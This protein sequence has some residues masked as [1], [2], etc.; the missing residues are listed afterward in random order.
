MFGFDIDSNSPRLLSL[1]EDR[2]LIE[3]DLS[4]STPETGLLLRGTPTRIEQSAVPTCFTWYP[5]CTKE[6]FIITANS[7]FKF[8]LCNVTTKMCRK[9]LLGPLFGSPVKNLV[10]V[11]RGDRA[12]HLLA[13]STDNKVGIALCPLDGNPHQSMALI[14]H[15]AAV[16]NVV[17]SH[18]G[19]TLFSV[20]GASVHMWGVN[21][22]VLSASCALKG[23]GGVPFIN[24][25]E[26]GNDGQMMEDIRNYFYY[27]QI[28]HQ[29][30]N[31]MEKRT[32]SHTMPLTEVPN[33]MRALGF[34]PSENEVLDMINEVKFGEYVETKKYVTTVDLDVLTRLYINHRPAIG[35]TLDDF[36]RAFAILSKDKIAPSIDTKEFLTKLQEKGEGIPELVL[37]QHLTSLLGE[38]GISSILDEKKMG[39][40]FFTEKI[41]GLC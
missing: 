20:G 1:G 21:A 32:V 31:S 14:A 18:D 9:T 4:K 37:A 16:T 2:M 8:K 36:D 35:I 33:V 11:P 10:P 19:T 12:Q 27:A 3:Y 41:L 6:P 25:L 7:D 24:M 38:K 28:R 22:N 5:D 13:F 17:S 15:P 40:N 39:A 29:G 34:Y 23:E 30:E 26:G